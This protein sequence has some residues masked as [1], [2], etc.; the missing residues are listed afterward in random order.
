MTNPARI[1]E[2]GEAMLQHAAAMDDAAAQLRTA[3]ERLES[4]P[5]EP[6]RCAVLLPARLPSAR[7]VLQ[8]VESIRTQAAAEGW[9]HELRIGVDACPET[10]TRLLR[11][12]VAHHFSERRLGPWLMRNSLM[13]LGP[14]DAWATFDSDDEMKPGYL[15]RLLPLAY[16]KG[17]AGGS[18][19]HVDQNE[20]RLSVALP[21]ES[22]VSVV[23]ACAMAQLGGWRTLPLRG[24][25]DLQHRADLLGIETVRTNQAQFY[26]RVHPG[27]ITMDPTLDVTRRTVL[28]ECE[29]LARLGKLRVQP[30]AVELEARTP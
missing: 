19:I 30:E 22:G 29:R 6:L 24:D 17:I 12:G 3:R 2:A 14:A 20:R 5:A 28:E 1:R 8:A 11:N 13:A 4:L 21:H 7:W 15:A 26:R 25:R 9:Q 27:A 18:R 10:S 16:P 23:S